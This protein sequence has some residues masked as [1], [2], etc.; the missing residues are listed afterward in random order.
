[1]TQRTFDCGQVQNAL[2]ALG[3]DAGAED[4]DVHEHGEMLARILG[5]Y[6]DRNGKYKGAWKQYGALSQLVRAANK[7]DRLMAVWWFEPDPEAMDQ[8]QRVPMDPADLDDAIDCINHL[9]FFLRNAQSG[10]L[11]GNPPSRPDLE[12]DDEECLVVKRGDGE[13]VRQLHPSRLPLIPVENWSSADD[14]T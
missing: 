5:T 7:I 3:L 13:V 1:M 14:E 10:N 12:G 4:H 9:L 8:A 6:V 2:Y 11:F